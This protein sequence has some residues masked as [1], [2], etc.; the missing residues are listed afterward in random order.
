MRI[1]AIP[2]SNSKKSINKQLLGYATRLIEGGLVDDAKV[3]LIDLNDYEMP[4]YSIDRQEEGGIPAAAQDFFDKIGQA[5]AVLI[6][7]AE[8]NG[9]YTAA[10]KN[11]FDWTSRID[12][13]V[14]Q[15]KPTVM[16]SASMGPGGG[17]NVLQAAVGSA[18]FF[19]NDVKASLSIP[20][21][22]QNFDVEGH[23]L[24][25]ADLDAQFREALTALS[26]SE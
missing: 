11:L 21:F 19:G 9:F 1:L 17:A 15:D 2:A 14:F 7:Y 6:S 20:S 16:F 5:D 4:I 24:S 22:G 8:H 3:E 23:L 18:P 12:M 26:P 10:Y 25:D 13:R